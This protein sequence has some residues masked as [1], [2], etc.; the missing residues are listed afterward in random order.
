MRRL[1]ARETILA[2]A[3][4]LTLLGAATWRWATPR[5]AE[6][7]EL[8]RAREA[9]LARQR[10]YRHIAGARAGLEERYAALRQKLPVYPP[11]RDVTAELLRMLERIANEQGVT[12]LRRDAAKERASDD[13]RE[14]AIACQWEGDLPQLVRLLFALQT[15]EGLLDVS[16][17]T[18]G[19]APGGARLRGTFT[20][21]FA[22]IRG[23]PTPTAPAPAAAP[24]E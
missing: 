1:T 8:R 2:G 13:L 19:P 15:G 7:R 18:V 9:Q 23:K 22:Y 20:V 24:R 14:Q 17:L 21:E 10:E 16:Q 11:D 12:L 5:L 4:A 6:W 3:A